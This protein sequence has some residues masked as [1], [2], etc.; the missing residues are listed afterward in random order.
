MLFLSDDLIQ[1]HL[2]GRLR[3]FEEISNKIYC[4]RGAIT[5][6]L[7][8]RQGLGQLDVNSGLPW[9]STTAV[10]IYMGGLGLFSV[11]SG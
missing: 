4:C 11:N 9:D 1:Y 10:R 8:H 2:Q 7:G 3:K 5:L 6:W